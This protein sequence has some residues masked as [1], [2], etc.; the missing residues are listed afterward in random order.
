MAKAPAKPA[1]DGTDPPPKSKKTLILVIVLVLLVVA[2]A[3]VGLLMT[4]KSSGNG[5]GGNTH[6]AAAVDHSKPPTFMTLEAFTTNLAKEDGDHYVQVEMVLRVSDSKVAEELKT[7]M[8]ELRHRVNLLLASKLPSEL[9]TMEGREG[10]AQELLDQANETLG[11][12]P[13]KRKS[14]RGEASGPVEAVLFNSF[15]IQ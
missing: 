5:E 7:L 13:P 2:G 10:L 11:Y 6:E 14:K 8:P 3:A 1:A 4:K 12:E 9:A 15:I